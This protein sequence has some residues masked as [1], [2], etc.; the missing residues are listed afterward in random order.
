MQCFPV[1]D[2]SQLAQSRARIGIIFKLVN[3]LRSAETHNRMRECTIT[4]RSLQNRPREFN[5][6][7]RAALREEELKGVPLG[8][9][10]GIRWCRGRG[11]SSGSVHDHAHR[12]R[13]RLDLRRIA[14]T[15]SLSRRAS[16]AGGFGLVAFDSAAAA[17]DAAGFDAG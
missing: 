17:G 6:E 15:R 7:A 4:L 3:L 5:G 11:S 8:V 2:H 13:V 9:R 12:S 16:L 10:G 1:L 14:L